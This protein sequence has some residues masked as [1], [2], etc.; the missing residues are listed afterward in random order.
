MNKICKESAIY[1]L[2]DKFMLL[3]QDIFINT[4][5]RKYPI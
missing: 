4:T 5:A 3:K 2:I 1:S